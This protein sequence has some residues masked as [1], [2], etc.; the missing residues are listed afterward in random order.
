MRKSI[1]ALAALVVVIGGLVLGYKVAY[2]TTVYTYRMTVEVDVNGEIRSGSSVIRVE[3]YVTPKWLPNGGLTI[4]HV[5]GDAVFVDLG[6]QRNVI[7]T[8][9]VRAGG[10]TSSSAENWPYWTT[11]RNGQVAAFAIPLARTA[12]RDDQMPMFVSFTKLNDPTTL[13]RIAADR[14]ERILG[15]GIKLKAVYVETSADP[16]TRSIAQHLPWLKAWPRGQ[17]LSG[18][19]R[20]AGTYTEIFLPMDLRTEG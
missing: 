19:S 7:A 6:S 5:Y 3:R 10:S 1:L 2:P 18:G 17:R 16:V 14:F 9:H 13:V 11:E 20:E 15:S 4:S 12:L 8:L